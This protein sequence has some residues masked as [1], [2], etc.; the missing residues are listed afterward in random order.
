MTTEQLVEA[1][2]ILGGLA[3]LLAVAASL[4]IVVIA[5]SES[6]A[7]GLLCLLCPPYAVVY[8]LTRWEACQTPLVASAL[9]GLIA[10]VSGAYGVAHGPP[11]P[12]L[13]HPWQ[14]L[15]RQISSQTV[16]ASDPERLAAD[17]RRLQGRWIVQHGAQ[18]TFQIKANQVRIRR[19]HS[20]DLYD[21][22]L[23]ATDGFPAVDLTSVLA[24]EV[25]KGIYLLQRDRCQL[26][27]GKPG[28]PRPTT[29]QSVAGQQELFVLQRPWN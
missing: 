26:C 12:Q 24:P 2:V 1:A 4:W 10:L 21:F 16:G 28:G 17:Q 20:E 3:G 25:T 5:F 19:R 6:V 14:Q 13:P 29:F 23:L 8:A 27:F 18:E 9:G 7:R 22:Q 15:W 11:P